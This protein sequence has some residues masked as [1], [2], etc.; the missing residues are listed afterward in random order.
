MTNASPRPVY[1]VRHDLQ[2]TL[3]EEIL[4]LLLDKEPCHVDMIQRAAEER[5]YRIAQRSPDQLVTSLVSLRLLQRSGHGELCLSMTG[6][7]V[8]QAAKYTP[9]LMPELIHFTYYT[10]YNETVRMPRF[11]WAYR[12]VCDYLWEA[13]DLVIDGHRL[14]ALVEESAQSLFAD[15][16]QFGVSFSLNSV[17]GILNWL[18]ALNPP[19]VVRTQD[20]SRR[21]VRRLSCPAELL[22]LALD[23]IRL[24]S[25]GAEA[26]Q[27]HLLA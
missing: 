13:R 19:A 23:Y 11:S 20:G 9:H 2:P 5:G 10:L 6:R 17:A 14:V 12:L 1:H 27:I 24:D 7:L 8:A 15:Y 25:G 16:D 4:L 26:R 22:L 18:E 3:T 21:F